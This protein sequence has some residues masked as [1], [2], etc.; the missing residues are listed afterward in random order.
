MRDI[1]PAHVRQAGD[2]G[3][4]SPVG[5]LLLDVLVGVTGAEADLVVVLAG[6]RALLVFVVTRSGTVLEDVGAQGAAVLTHPLL[7][8]ER[9]QSEPEHGDCE[10]DTDHWSPPPA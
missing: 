1:A 4:R 9:E 6:D 5:W 8:T 7:A 10:W 3:P 2:V